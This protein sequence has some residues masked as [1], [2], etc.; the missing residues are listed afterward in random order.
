MIFKSVAAAGEPPSVGST[1]AKTLE[2]DH[3]FICIDDPAESQRLLSDAGFQLGRRGTHKG[4]GTAN[5]CAFFDNAYLEL[6]WRHDDQEL[7]S[8]AVRPVALWER[9]RWRETGACPFGIAVRPGS[10]DL[11]IETWAYEAPFLPDGA[12]I[13]IVTPRFLCQEPLLFLS[14]V[15]QAPITLPS[16]SRPPLEHRGQNRRLTGVIVHGPKPSRLS[17]GLRYFCG[18]NVLTLDRAEEAH[19]ELV[20]DGGASGE[21]C[22]FRPFV[23]LVVRC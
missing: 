6:L 19:L 4:Q 17:A 5:A 23:P 14:L 11:P 1:Q 22:D 8:E 16:E 12:N 3:V 2:L 7:Q 15:S 18:L 21:S 13:P 20:W 10:D 9:V